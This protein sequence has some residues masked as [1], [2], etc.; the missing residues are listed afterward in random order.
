MSDFRDRIS[1]LTPK[2]LALLALELHDQVEAMQERAHEP[3]AVVGFACRFPGADDTKSFWELL[4]DGRDAIDEVPGNRWDIDAYFD[5]DPDRPGRMA[6]R[7]GGFLADIAGFDAGFFGIA[8]REAVSMD[9]QQRLLL[10]VTWEAL[11][12]AGIAADRLSGS[13][14]GVFVGICNNDH[15]QRVLHRGGELID[16]YLASGHA[17][18]VAAGRISYCLGLQGP[19]LSID[20]A[21]S[22][23][24]AALHVACRSLQNGESQLALCAGVNVMC[25]PE[26][27]IALSRGHMLAPDGRCKT[28]DAR[29]DGFSRGEGCGVLVLKRLSDAVSDSDR[30]LAVIRGTAVNQDGR[31]GGLTV[32]NGPAQEAVIRAA[33][34]AARVEPADIS[35]VEAHGTGTSLGDPIEV[36]ALAG[37][38]GAG[39]SHDNP[40]S[41]GSVKTNIG[42][43]EA[44]AGIAGVIKVILSLQHE[45]IPPHLHF[46]QPSPHIPWSEY[47]VSVTANGKPWRR[48]ARPRLA[49]VSS[50]GFSGTNVHAVIEE[51]PQMVPSTMAVLQRPLHCLPLSAR[52]ETALKRLAQ[53]Y[54]EDMG[55]HPDVNLVDVAQTAGAGRSH[56]DRRVAVVAETKDVAT[57]ALCAFA[58][59]EPHSAVHRGTVVPGQAPEVVFLFTGQGCQYPGMGRRLYET[60]PVFRD[61]IDRCDT[62][63]GP[64][65]N[66][67]TLKTVLWSE[68]SDPTIHD[69]A[70]TQPTLFAVEYGLAQLWR[71][72]GIEPAAV[73]GH[74]VGE[75]VAACVAGVFTLEEGLRLIAERGRLMGAL[76][77][78]GAMAAVF[79]SPD[80]VAAAIAAMGARIGIAAI[81]APENVVISGEAAAVDALLAEFAQREVRG[82]KLFVSL[83]AHSPLVEPALDALEACARSV[84]MR[85]PRIPVAWNL[86]GAAALEFGSAPDAVY[87]R[88]HLREPV[89]FAA[90]IESLYRDGYRT[91]LEVGPHPTLIGLTQ[92]SLQDDRV[93]WLASLHRD[94][95]DWDELLRSVGKLYVHGAPVDW[96]A[97]GQP[98]GGRRV[99]LPTYPFERQSYWLPSPEPGMRPQQPMPST[100]ATKSAGPADQK[101]YRLT[102]EPVPPITRAAASLAAP[103]QF[104]T[105]IRDRFVNLAEQHR[106]SIYDQLLPELDQLS[107]DHVAAALGQ[108]GFDGSVGRVFTADSEAARLGV[109][110]R[111]TRLFA[112]ILEMLTEDGILQPKG[113][114][115]KVI[116][117]LSSADPNQRY[118][119]LLARFGSVDGELRMLRRCGEE[120]ARVLSGNQDPLQLLFPGG[121]FAEAR[122]L[123]AESPYARTY[124][125]ALA[126]ALKAAIA[127]LPA[128][129]RLRV[130]EIGAGTG[131]TTTYVLPLLP[132]DRVEYTFT[133]LSPLFLDRAAAQFAAYQFLRRATLDIERD[134]ASQGFQADQYDIIIAA[135]VLHAT[136]DLRQTMLHVRSLL[137]P[138]GLLF[139]LEGV[140]PERWVDLSFG[141]TEG[142]WRFSDGSLRKSYPLISRAAWHNLLAALDFNNIVTIPDE[143]RSS[144][145]LDHQVLIVARAPFARRSWTLI[146]D[147]DGVGRAL[148]IRLRARGDTVKLLNA[149]ALDKGA[150]AEGELVYLGALDLA[151]R[152][153]DDPEVVDLCKSLAC[154]LP[155]RWLAQGGIDSGPK[156]MWLVTRG[157]QPI[158]GDASPGARWQAPVWGLGRTFALEQPERWGGL[159]DLPFE[160]SVQAL[161]EIL[162]TA[163]DVD[164]REDQTAWRQGVRF[165]A[166]LAPV[167]RPSEVPIRFRPDAT[168]LITGGFGAIGL[169]LAHWMAEHGAQ[170]LALLGRH[171][172]TTSDAVRAIE[173][174]GARVIPLEGDVGD[175]AAMRTLLTRL[176]E[177]SPPL[178]GIMHAALNLSFA[179]I[180]EL[181][182]VQVADMLRA[183]IDGTVLLERLTDGQQ[184]D[185]QVLFS[186]ATA[187]FGAWRSAHYSAAS[188]F[189]DATAQTADQQR[190]RVLSINWGAWENR[191]GGTA[192][193]NQRLFL[194]ESGFEPLSSN[195]ALGALGQLLAGSEP[196]TIVARIDWNLLKPLLEAGRPR[197]LLSLVAPGPHVM[198]SGDEKAPIAPGSNLI[199]RLVHS[200]AATR[201]DVLTEFVRTEAAVALGLRTP[202][203]VD[204]ARSLFNI[205]MDSLMAIELK[206]RLERGV[207]ATLP[208]ALAFNYP[209]VNDLVKFLDKIVP[210]RA[211]VTDD[212]LQD[213]KDILNRLPNMPI[214]EVDSLL[215]KLL[216]EENQA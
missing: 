7:A 182:Q 86:T 58:A 36:R 84:P 109:L 206:S 88:R 55:T 201:K 69:T 15:F 194:R 173:G 151:A 147:A 4:R 129:A 119:A 74:S 140:A 83:A 172:D 154:D 106:V 98:Y 19:A 187:I 28:F 200:S 85:A 68:A 122:Q 164:D 20:T 108:L 11:E 71:S 59:G 97:V 105:A 189:L 10:E 21:C 135:N 14:T 145:V 131:G 70:W 165:G 101:S 153:R 137:A 64:D 169:L 91:F 141:L 72:W 170:H 207:A 167:P 73:I 127:S 93:V 179:S 54:A 32:P 185:F 37:V 42:H 66:S 8:P 199:E 82:Q 25:S 112:R 120:L 168:Y 118:D 136:A 124:N 48:A 61:A 191:A 171:P 193:A 159:V 210:E 196:Q 161:A 24:L 204:P 128:S 148:A 132:A 18:S 174:L 31:S 125:G 46:R 80:V 209:T 205:G 99:S 30:I 144:R 56:F 27:T 76:P 95:N 214:T 180:Q 176:A 113:I 96:A 100:A 60:S 92:Q 41:I 133:D 121:S 175:E 143:V 65:A 142:W 52:S 116:R 178:R 16:A 40:L 163:L 77:S 110:T 79:A 78:G 139:L 157:V 51:A 114:A 184:L 190:T 149:D 62:L 6:V 192:A 215:A 26:T 212:N 87:W 44:A 134:P 39:R 158:D 211:P 17:L 183:K 33:L 5:P 23:S 2:R 94:R 117:P 12:H 53:R 197:P 160:G 43:L 152:Q 3:I 29:A 126:E 146:G 195:E 115:F 47:P 35:Y 49:G 203:L 198:K 150:V 104:A 13:P 123:Y 45:Y 90:G 177:Q 130:L 156:R 75:Y 9:P 166:R 67:R 213:V 202:D 81:N 181:T 22:A 107:A 1:N 38:L 57:A 63:L 186:S 102:W 155:L 34:A 111:H 162:L 50:F 188:V 208:S 89:R 103:E 216:M 138:S